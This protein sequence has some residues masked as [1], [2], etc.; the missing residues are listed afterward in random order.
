MK[1][2]MKKLAMLT[3]IVG[4]AILMA[5]CTCPTPKKHVKR[6]PR[7]QPATEAVVFY[8]TYE[9][10]DVNRVYAKMYTHS[11]SGGESRMGHIK[12][13]ETDAGLKMEVDLKD[14]RPN[15]SYTVKVY[16]C[17]TCN[18]GSS[19]CCD[20]SPMPITLPKLMVQTAGTLQETFMIR[21]LRAAQLQNG[22]IYLE[23]NGGYKAAW[24]KF[25]QPVF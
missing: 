2:L 8:Q 16:Q 21:G 18:N 3:S 22:K 19:T 10:S 24:G 4:V 9:D 5:G 11:T 20:N 13:T 15:V 25:E 17:G 6:H 1:T 23:R 14:L 7:P 12:F